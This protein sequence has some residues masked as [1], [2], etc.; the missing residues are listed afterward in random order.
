MV[1]N[2][3]FYILLGVYGVGL[4]SGESN[5]PAVVYI[6]ATRKC[7][8]LGMKLGLS[9][10]VIQKVSEY[11]YSALSE[12][13]NVDIDRMARAVYHVYLR[14]VGGLSRSVREVLLDG[15]PSWFKLIPLAERYV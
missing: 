1:V 6:E 13:P 9:E 12:Y 7:S 4:L 11:V 10:E 8:D 2:Y 14:K 5:V 15:T 3:I